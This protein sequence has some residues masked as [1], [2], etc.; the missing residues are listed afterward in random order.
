MSNIHGELGDEEEDLAGWDQVGKELG[1]IIEVESGLCLV[2]I[3][4]CHLLSVGNA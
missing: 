2:S 4:N 1:L 3:I